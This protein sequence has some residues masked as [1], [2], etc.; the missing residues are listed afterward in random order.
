MC[1][2][3]KLLILSLALPEISALELIPSDAALTLLCSSTTSPVANIVWRKD[4][5]GLANESHYWTTQILTNGVTA[6]YN[7][8]LSINASPSE[9]V[10][11]YSCIVRDSLGRHSETSTIQ[12]NGT[13]SSFCYVSFF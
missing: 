11:E 12:V 4:G 6:A 7:N 9:L 5:T 8:F 13:Q 10:G 3:Y 2:C 1:P